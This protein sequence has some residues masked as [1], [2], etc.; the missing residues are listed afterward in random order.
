[1]YESICTASLRNAFASKFNVF[2][3]IIIWSVCSTLDSLIDSG[4]PPDVILD[5]TYGN[6]SG[7]I[8]SMSLRFGLPTV[9]SSIGQE[10]DIK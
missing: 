3:H 10:N 1:M 7:V 2:K 8:K 5:L 4:N 9:S 6:N